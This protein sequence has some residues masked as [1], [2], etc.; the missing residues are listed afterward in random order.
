MRVRYTRGVGLFVGLY[1]QGLLLLSD[2][3]QNLN[4][5]IF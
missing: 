1:T 4:Y 3:K 2:F 5:H